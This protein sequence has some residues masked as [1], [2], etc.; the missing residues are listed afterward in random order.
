MKW[1]KQVKHHTLALLKLDNKKNPK[2]YK[3]KKIRNQK[4]I[5]SKLG[6]KSKSFLNY[7]TQKIVIRFKELKANLTQIYGTKTI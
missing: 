1:N 5:I 7:K 6:I 2:Y 4:W 3:T